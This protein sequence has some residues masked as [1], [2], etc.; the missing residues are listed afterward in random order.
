MAYIRE[1]SE[2]PEQE[3]RQLRYKRQFKNDVP[4]W[5]DSMVLAVNE[6]QEIL[7]EKCTAL[8]LGCGHGNYVLD[9]LREHFS[10]VI[11]IDVDETVSGKNTTIT[12]L[13][14]T[15]GKMLPVA[16]ENVELVTALWVLEHLDY[17]RETFAEV[18]RVL[19]PGGLFIFT[20]PNK[21]ALIVY[22]RRLMPYAFAR[23][24]VEKVYGRPTSDVFPVFYRANTVRDIHRLL[25]SEQWTEI[26]L[27]ENVDPSYTSFSEL[28]Y[29]ISRFLA[30]KLPRQNSPHLIGIYQ[31]NP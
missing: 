9:E 7:P 27:K 15:D 3:H 29:K 5:D 1:Y 30:E 20:T 8:D 24:V 16:N 11:G 21:N 13:R 4:T 28:T 19:K 12:E 23:R 14:I 10:S 17:P 26:L 2:L 18:A 22:A 6:L 25:P 31:K